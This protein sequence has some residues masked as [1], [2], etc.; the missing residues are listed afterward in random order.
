MSATAHLGRLT[1]PHPPH[2]SVLTRLRLR[3]LLAEIAG[4][5]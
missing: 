2:Q 3:H 5:L 4:A 1:P